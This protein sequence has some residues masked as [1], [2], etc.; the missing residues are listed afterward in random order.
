LTSVVKGIYLIYIESYN[1]FEGQSLTKQDLAGEA[2]RL[3]LITTKLLPTAEVFGLSALLL[4][5][6]ARRL[7]RSSVTAS[8]IPLESQDR[9]LW[10]KETINQANVLIDQAL[11]FQ[12]PGPYQI[13][14]AISALHAN[15]QSWAA[16]DW[17]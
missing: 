13:Q 11:T 12:Q 7:S 15:G 4:F 9:A 3:S 14:A 5:H 16:T 17:R 2:I 8:Y 10:N 6:D 1:A